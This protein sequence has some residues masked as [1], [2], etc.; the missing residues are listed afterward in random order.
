M[1][2]YVI[3]FFF[4]L[5]FMRT[6]IFSKKGV[7]AIIYHIMAVLP[8]VFLLT[9]RSVDCGTDTINYTMLFN[10]IEKEG[11]FAYVAGTRLEFLFASIM[12]G[13]KRMGL[14]IEYL[15]FISA[16]LTILP[17]YIGSLQI[18]KFGVNPLLP[19][20][21]FYLFFYQYSFNIVRQSIAMS[22]VF[23]SVVY[24]IQNKIRS[25]LLVMII[26][27]LFHYVATIS[28]I[29]FVVYITRF[30]STR[31]RALIVVLSSV[32][33]VYLLQYVYAV[34][35]DSVMAHLEESASLQM[36]YFVEMAINLLFVAFA[37]KK[38]KTGLKR[39]FLFVSC[40][41]LII[42]VIGSQGAYMFRIA[43]ALDI[44]L[45]I[46]IPLAL[47]H[48]KNRM[49]IYSYMSFAVAFWWY[50]FILRGNGR[51]CPYI[52]SLDFFLF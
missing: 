12:F 45:L 47:K 11:L 2:I 24:L 10:N 34:K 33:I 25:S 46:Y 3:S 19:M 32:I 7:V 41:T 22:F 27:V 30:Q 1:I 52:S 16:I 40:L 9:F 51:T 18:R 5:L 15:F 4:S 44:L 8:P 42:L 20:A 31:N 21:F 13:V 37:W 14:S 28:I 49:V 35:A 23:L 17:I 26:A 43:N 39:F 29:P 6:A 50:I 36:S 38:D 48:S